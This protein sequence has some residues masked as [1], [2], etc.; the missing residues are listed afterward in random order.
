MQLL[1]GVIDL[2]FGFFHLAF[3]QLFRWPERLLASGRFNTAVTQ[4]LNVML[5]YVFFLYGGVLTAWALR[6]EAMHPIM[7]GA[8]AGFWTLRFGLHFVW[9]DIRRPAAIA[10]AFLFLLA[11]AVHGAAAFR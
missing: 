11:A 6:A 5:T 3:W 8:G 7:L 1:A 10:I 9:F 2:A 4:T